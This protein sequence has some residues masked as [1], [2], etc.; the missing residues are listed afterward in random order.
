MINGSQK[1]GQYV[2]KEGDTVSGLARQFNIPEQ[3]LI[4]ANAFSD[5]G[6]LEI[7]QIIYLPQGNTQSLNQTV[8]P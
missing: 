7:G 8:A 6:R 2:V 5:P 4:S 3:E 1:S